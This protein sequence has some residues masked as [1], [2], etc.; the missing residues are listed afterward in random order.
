MDLIRGLTKFRDD[1][2]DGTSLG[3]H[4][5]RYG[6]HKANL[7]T[8]IDEGMAICANPVSQ[9][10]GFFLVNGIRTKL[11]STVDGDI[12]RKLLWIIEEKDPLRKGRGS[13]VIRECLVLS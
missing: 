9:F 13:K 1:P 7:A 4:R 11:G 10:F 12:H 2:N 6:T 8:S 5:V 3:K